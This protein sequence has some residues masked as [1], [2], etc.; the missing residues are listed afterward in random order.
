MVY[1]GLV[2]RP[3]LRVSAIRQQTGRQKVRLPKIGKEV[4]L[5]VRLREKVLL[6][7]KLP[8]EPFKRNGWELILGTTGEVEQ[9]KEVNFKLFN[10]SPC[11]PKRVLVRNWED[12]LVK[13]DPVSLNQKGHEANEE[14]L[15]KESYGELISRILIWDI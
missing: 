13:V 3:D 15:T 4:V 6:I 12:G 8:V 9:A 10:R 11:I 5:N 2:S 14:I 1:V 7:V